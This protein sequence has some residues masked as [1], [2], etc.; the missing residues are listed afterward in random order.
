MKFWILIFISIS[1]L[2]QTPE[3]SAKK[4]Y[5]AN[6]NT[7]L[8]FTSESGLSS[9]HYRFTKSDFKMQSYSLP[10]RH[11]FKPLD[12]KMNWFANGGVGY[13]ITR[14]DTQTRVSRSGTDIDLRHDNKLQ[15]YTAGLG[16]GL[17]YKSE[18]GVDFSGGMGLIYSRVGTSVKPED[19]IGD[20]IKD[21]FD[22]QYNDN[23]TYKLFISAEYKKEIE[24]F[25][26]YGKI[27]LKSYETKADFTFDVLAGF[28]TQSDVA[29]FSVG[30]E[31]PSLMKYE[32]NYL[33]LE[34]YIKFNYLHGDITDVV[35]FKKYINMGV[36]AYWN[37]PDFPSW[38]RRFY[39]EVSTVRAEGLEG[40]N[41]AMGF[42]LEL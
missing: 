6:I 40:Y 28:T 3:G 13:S 35:R 29:T 8:V 39:A 1:L 21:F 11:H 37:T 41:I 36:L 10:F 18:M 9:G 15:T 17:R 33:S 32:E 2:A 38:A 27:D 20:A 5:L 22:S 4:A 31:T 16:G 12:S 24:G 30:S 14:L 25:K 19:D 23:I 7:L 26:P 34:G 42:S